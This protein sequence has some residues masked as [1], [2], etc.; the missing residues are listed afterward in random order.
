[1]D[2]YYIIDPIPWNISVKH[3]ELV[4]DHFVVS[5]EGAK[6]LYP[7]IFNTETITPKKFHELKKKLDCNKIIILDRWTGEEIVS[8][9]D[10]VNRSGISGLRGNTPFQEMPQFPDVSNVYTPFSGYRKATVMTVGPKRFPP[11]E[12]EKRV[13]EICGIVAPVW[14]YVGVSVKALCVPNQNTKYFSQP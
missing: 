6:W 5:H 4:A 1:M 11:V 7:K 13:S 2:H 3:P 9:I 12:K 10:H 14:F 8:V